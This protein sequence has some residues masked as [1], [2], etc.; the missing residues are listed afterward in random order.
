MELLDSFDAPA[1]L[2]YALLQ[3]YLNQDKYME[4]LES[5]ADRMVLV[6]KKHFPILRET[7]EARQAEMDMEDCKRFLSQGQTGLQ[8]DVGQQECSV[9]LSVFRYNGISI[10]S[11]TEEC[12]MTL[13]MGMF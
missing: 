4:E 8:L 12:K 7:Y 3:M 10:S 1:E 5:L 9:Y 6:L 11:Q 2:K 13:L